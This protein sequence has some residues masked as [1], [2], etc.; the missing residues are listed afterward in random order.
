MLTTPSGVFAL[1]LLI[2]TKPPHAGMEAVI[3]TTSQEEIE[4]AA[5][6]EDVSIISVVG[7]TVEEAAELR[8]HI[9]ERV[10]DILS[11]GVYIACA[12]V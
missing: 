2:E 3:Q 7:K 9:P 11:A 1:D 8:Q 5:A 12:V 10:R 4:Q 6:S